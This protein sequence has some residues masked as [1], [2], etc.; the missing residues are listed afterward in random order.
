[1]CNEFVQLMA[2]NPYNVYTGQCLDWCAST[3]YTSQ[4][5]VEFTGKHSGK[6]MAQK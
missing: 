4:D 6:N 1:M 5:H 3:T 2:M